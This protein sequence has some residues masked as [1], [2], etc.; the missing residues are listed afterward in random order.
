M[1]SSAMP[2]VLLEHTYQFTLMCQ[3]CV[4]L[5]NKVLVVYYCS[6]HLDCRKLIQS[7]LVFGQNN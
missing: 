2:D 3:D 6:L 4:K 1:T 7:T 5:T